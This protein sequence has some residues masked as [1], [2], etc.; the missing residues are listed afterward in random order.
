MH[1]QTVLEVFQSK[2]FQ[3]EY[4]CPVELDDLQKSTEEYLRMI[5]SLIREL[6]HMF[7]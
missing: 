5:E 6:E 7:P 1:S 4:P 2:E 3:A